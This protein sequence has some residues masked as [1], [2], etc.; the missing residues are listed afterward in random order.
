MDVLYIMFMIY[1]VWIAYL[2]APNIAARVN[3]VVI[4]I[5]TRPGI[6]SGGK[7]SDS[8]A[9]ITNNPL[10]RYVWSKW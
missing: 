9:T 4:A 7:K 1:M 8:Q 3:K 10:G 5:V 2:T 6:D